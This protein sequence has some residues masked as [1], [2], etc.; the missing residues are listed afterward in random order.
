[1]KPHPALL[2]VVHTLHSPLAEGRGDTD[3]RARSAGYDPPVLGD[4]NRPGW[5]ELWSRLPAL[6]APT[7]IA[8]PEK[9]RP[10]QSAYCTVSGNDGYQYGS[11]VTRSSRTNRSKNLPRKRNVTHT[12]LSVLLQGGATLV[13][14]KE[15]KKPLWSIRSFNIMSEKQHIP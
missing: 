3:G 10:E 14:S 7:V 8:P 1:M 12:K 13:H 9:E 2:L 5:S 11:V 15:N 4:R 6:A